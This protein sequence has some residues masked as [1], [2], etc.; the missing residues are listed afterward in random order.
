MALDPKILE[1]RFEGSAY[2]LSARRLWEHTELGQVNVF[3]HAVNSLEGQNDSGAF[4]DLV[5]MYANGLSLVGC[6]LSQW[7]A[8]AH[9]T[10]H[11][12]AF[13][14]LMPNVD[15]SAAALAFVETVADHLAVCA[16][17]LALRNQH[18]EFLPVARHHDFFGKPFINSALVRHLFI[19]GKAK[20]SG[21][22]WLKT[23][24][25]FQKRG[26]RS[27]ELKHSGLLR[28]L[29]AQD[30]KAGQIVTGDVATMCNFS[31]I[32]LAVIPVVSDAK[33]QLRFV[34]APILPLKRAKKLPKAQFGHS[35]AVVEIDPVLGYRL[36]KIEHEALWG[37]DNHWQ[38]VAH[39]GR[40]VNNDNNQN[41]LTTAEAAAALAASD[42]SLRFPKRLALGRWAHLAWTGGKDYREWLVTLPYYPASYF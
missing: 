4:V 12:A 19:L 14:P 11:G 31:A 38:A 21:K 34:T 32:R 1:V 18:G 20:A 3:E 6:T 30:D 28:A 5:W 7:R 10:D 16:M 27:D 25:N 17:R 41:L 24:E 29:L 33:R 23:V 40:V 36:E 39:D 42:A 9:G 15:Q 2:G 35:R 22:Q 13:T 37:T 8:G 26:L